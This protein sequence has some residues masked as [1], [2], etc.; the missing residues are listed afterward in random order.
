MS[1]PSH[2]PENC[3]ILC[4]VS[5]FDFYQFFGNHLIL[6]HSAIRGRFKDT[7]RS[8]GL[9]CMPRE[10]SQLTEIPQG[11]THLTQIFQLRH[12]VYILQPI[13]P[14]HTSRTTFC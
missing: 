6:R 1:V 11:T 14:R 8:G 2:L 3:A 9:L 10:S 13:M 4:F 7:Y 12:L 5:R